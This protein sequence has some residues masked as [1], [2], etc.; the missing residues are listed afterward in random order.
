MYFNLYKTMQINDAHFTFCV[1]LKKKS[2][3]I[4]KTTFIFI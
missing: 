3:Q 4:K 2:T 1:K